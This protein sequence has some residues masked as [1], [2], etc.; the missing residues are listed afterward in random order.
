MFVVVPECRHQIRDVV[1]VQSVEPV[2]AIAPDLHEP[3][4]A[5]QTKLVRG[6]A[7]G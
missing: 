1:I 5:K 6:G 2:P 7:L 3:G 4:L